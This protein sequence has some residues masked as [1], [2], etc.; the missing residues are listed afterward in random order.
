MKE[1]GKRAVYAALRNSAGEEA[2]AWVTPRAGARLQDV[3]RKVA[4]QP[5]CYTL[6]DRRVVRR[7]GLEWELCPAE[8]FQ[9]HQFYGFEDPVYE[10]LRACIEPGERFVDVGANVG[11][12]TLTVADRV[13]STGR[14]VAFEPGPRTHERLGQHLTRNKHL[15]GRV[16]LRQIAVSDAEGLCVMHDYG[17]GDSGKLSARAND[18]NSSLAPVE[19]RQSTLDRELGP[20]ACDLIKIDVEGLEPEVLLGAV[21]TL[22]RSQPVVVIEVSPKWYL[23]RTEKARRAFELLLEGSPR[24][25]EIAEARHGGV[26]AVSR[27]SVLAAALAGASGKQLN[28][29]VVPARR[30]AALRRLQALAVLQAD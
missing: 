17:A 21:E 10:V 23:D 29:A 8:Y 12:Y 24:V 27:P 18:S 19:V 1:L 26:R 30:E 25:F 7:R 14:V 4:P 2:L 28:V 5:Y 13:G 20:P 15:A 16:E 9:W 3:L 11:F 22:Q 6:T